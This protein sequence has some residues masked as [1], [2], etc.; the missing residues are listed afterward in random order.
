MPASSRINPTKPGIS[1]SRR[2]NIEV[3]A[4]TLRATIAARLYLNQAFCENFL[5]SHRFL[6]KT[7]P[8]FEAMLLRPAKQMVILEP[9]RSE[10]RFALLVI[11]VRLLRA[12]H[13]TSLAPRIWARYSLPMVNKAADCRQAL[14]INYILLIQSKIVPA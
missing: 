9:S 6:Q 11:V 4:I 5:L 10:R 8:V 1:P 7:V 14:Q 13:C 12:P 2:G 3:A